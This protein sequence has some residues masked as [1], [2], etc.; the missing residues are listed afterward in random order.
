MSLARY[1]AAMLSDDKPWTQPTLD[2]RPCAVCL[3][4][5]GRVCVE[6]RPLK[7]AGAHQR[8]ACGTAAMVTRATAH[9][10]CLLQGVTP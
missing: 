8:S 4:A 7:F 6:S 3:V 2:C 9:G 10:V 1:S 5:R